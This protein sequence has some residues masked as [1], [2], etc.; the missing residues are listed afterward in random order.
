MLFT[1]G[2]AAQPNALA[3]SAKSLCGALRDLPLTG[4]GDVIALVG[5]GASE[6]AAAGAAPVWRDQGLRAFAVSASQLLKTTMPVADLYVGLSESGRSAE[7]VAALGQLQGTRRVGLTNFSDSPLVAVVDEALCLDS[8]PDS[9]IYTTGYTATLQA[10]GLLGEHWSGQGTNWSELPE[11]AATVLAHAVPV[12]ADLTSVLAGARV[13]DIV[14]TGASST[15]AGEGALMLRESARLLTA[16]HETYNYL[17]GPMEPLDAQTACVIIGDGRELRL[18]RDTSELGCPTLLITTRSDIT[19]SKTLTVLTLPRA[20]SPLA[21]AVLEI[22]PLQQ[23]AWA[24]ASDRGLAVD[25]FRYHQDD[26]KLS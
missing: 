20:S 23:L 17:H 9:P 7:T 1:D 11:M 24:V 10:L 19:S 18:A 8:G 12:V 2:I 25:G 3:R 22:L 15:T 13:V 4:P 16:S 6:H 14:A 21:Q 26:T 5:I